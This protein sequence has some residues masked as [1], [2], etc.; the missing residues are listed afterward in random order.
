VGQAMKASGGRA[1]P[2]RVGEIVRELTIRS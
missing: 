1:D 2:A